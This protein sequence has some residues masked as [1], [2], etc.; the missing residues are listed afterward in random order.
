[1]FVF[2]FPIIQLKECIKQCSVLIHMCD[3]FGFE[4]DDNAWNWQVNTCCCWS[5]HAMSHNIASIIFQPMYKLDW[6]NGTIFYN[7]QKTNSLNRQYFWSINRGN[8]F[9]QRLQS[10]SKF[11]KKK[12]NHSLCRHWKIRRENH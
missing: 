12:C 1:M 7:S 8:I 4:E 6:P 3:A 5:E 11:H 10:M 2:K 9:R